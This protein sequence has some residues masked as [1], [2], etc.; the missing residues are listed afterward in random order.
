MFFLRAIRPPASGEE[1]IN[2]KKISW[3]LNSLPTEVP[4]SNE[5]FIEYKLNVGFWSVKN[6]THYVLGKH[7]D[8]TKAQQILL[9]KKGKIQSV[10]QLCIT[11]YWKGPEPSEKAENIIYKHD[12]LDPPISV[13]LAISIMQESEN[14]PV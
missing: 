8:T 1:F 11:H 5:V 4:S 13:Q 2:Q 6:T 7:L 10:T 3:D 12:Y 14:R 9:A